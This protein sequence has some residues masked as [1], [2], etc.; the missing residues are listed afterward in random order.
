MED[1]ISKLPDE[2]LAHILSFLRSSTDAVRSSV[3]SRQWRYIWL[4]LQKFQI[5]DSYYYGKT[6]S[7]EVFMNSFVNFMNRVLIN[8]VKY[9]SL[10][11][12]QNYSSSDIESWLCSVMT[13][14]LEEIHLEGSV[15][16]FPAKYSK[17]VCLTGLKS[18]YLEYL[19]NLS[20]FNVQMLLSNCPIL[21]VLVIDR[22]WSDDFE[23][24]NVNSSSLKKFRYFDPYQ[25]SSKVVINAPNLDNLSIHVDRKLNI[26]VKTPCSI[27]KARFVVSSCVG[28]SRADMDPTVQLLRKTSNISCLSASCHI[29]KLLRDSSLHNLPS[30]TRL[31]R[32]IVSNCGDERSYLPAMLTMTPNLKFIRFYQN[33]RCN[34]YMTYAQEL[35][36]EQN[37]AKCLKSSLES[38]EFRGLQNVGEDMEIV[39]YLLKYAKLL[40][41]FAITCYRDESEILR[42]VLMFPRASIT[43]LISVVPEIHMWLNTRLSDPSEPANQLVIKECA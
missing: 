24:L 1:R 30:F 25:K 29:P 38:V 39:A 12:T 7:T 8:N 17:S 15:I 20:D 33:K 16:R 14:N 28:I 19:T 22:G 36:P 35:E 4:K 34:C 13:R 32:L 9:L 18:L 6:Y 5:C 40:N 42:K 31:T 27:A 3:L 11:L 43:C 23:I 37:V 26:E 21:E 10:R 2:I 41:T